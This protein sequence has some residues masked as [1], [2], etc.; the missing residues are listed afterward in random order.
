MVWVGET[1]NGLRSAGI[2]FFL[3]GVLI[4]LFLSIFFG[5][6]LLLVGLVI[7]LAGGRRH[8]V[9]SPVQ[10]ASQPQNSATVTHE[11]VLGT[12]C[13]YCEVLNDQGALNCQSCSASLS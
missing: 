8:S 9:T 7:V 5:L 13:K 12:K 4:F 2:L 10:S 11:V 3:V 1:L 6:I